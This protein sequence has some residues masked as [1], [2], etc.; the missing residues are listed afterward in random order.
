MR[1]SEAI[2]MVDQLSPMNVSK[3]YY[4]ISVQSTKTFKKKQVQVQVKQD[5]NGSQV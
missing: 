1:T 3:A 4:D 5:L 2:V